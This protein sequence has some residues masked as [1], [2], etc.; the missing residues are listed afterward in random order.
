MPPDHTPA[1]TR[2]HVLLGYDPAELANDR[3]GATTRASSMLRK[4]RKRRAAACAPATVKLQVL[5]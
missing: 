3:S 2:F 1:R 4:V 5:P